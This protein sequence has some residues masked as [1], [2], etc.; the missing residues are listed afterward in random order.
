M[1]S[2]IRAALLA[3]IT[4]LSG[5]GTFWGGKGKPDYQTVVTPPVRDENRAR[6]KNDGA[7]RHL[8]RRNL[9]KAERLVQESLIADVTY[10][11]AHNTLGRVYFEQGKLYLAAWEFE[12]ARRMMP[13]QP[14][15]I[16]NLGLVFE[17]AEKLD[18]AIA[19]FEEAHALAPNTPDYLGNLL[20]AK[21][22]RGDDESDL[23]PLAQKLVFIET[24]S[25]WAH[26]ARE[27]LAGLSQASGDGPG[28]G[29]GESLE[30]ILPKPADVDGSFLEER[31]AGLQQ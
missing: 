19:H 28:D 11:P 10:G 25:D 7:I 26:W 24:R 12:Y 21:L 4:C 23:A 15:P 30:E 3:I 9:E 27:M 14:E 13:D 6:E 5:C 1:R 16:N 17:A 2:M 20:R 8:E 18:I 29:L 31:G 22:K